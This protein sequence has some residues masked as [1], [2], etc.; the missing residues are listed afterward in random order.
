MDTNRNRKVKYVWITAGMVVV[1]IILLAVLF[2]TLSAR[3]R[4]A[5]WGGLARKLF[6]KPVKVEMKGPKKAPLP[7]AKPQEP[8]PE[9]LV[10]DFDVGLTAGIFKHRKNRIGSYQGTWAMRPSFA[11][12]TK[13]SEI[14][15]GDHG[16]SLIIDYKKEAGWCGYY[17]LL[18]NADITPYNTLSFWVKGEKGGE[19]FDIGL[20]DARMQD[21][22]IDAFFLGSVA[23]FVPGG[24]VTTEWKEVKVPLARASS[25]LDLTRMGSLVLW[26]KYGGEGRVYV[27]DIKFK[28]DSEVA[29]IEEYNTPQAQKDPLHPRSLWVWKIDPVSSVKQRKE[30]FLLCGK[31]A[32][33]VLYLFFPEFTEAPEPEYLK[34]MSEF[35]RESL[36]RGVKVEA[37]TGNPVWSLAE[38]H[39]LSLYWIRFFLDYNKDR[40]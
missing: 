36:K 26:F 33:S 3:Q 32:I 6:E 1:L 24:F 22:E 5:G 15:R 16:Q 34:A 11:I 31:T 40:P 28:N 17:T 38:N 30:M 8:P 10:D 4:R 21:L 23:S 9:L 19:K 25:E 39:L 2:F 12:I 13:S 29:K 27:E 35:L 20:A 14:R 37:L 7:A 18:N